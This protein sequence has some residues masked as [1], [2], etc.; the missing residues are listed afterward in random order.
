MHNAIIILDSPDFNGA[1]WD[2][3][4]GIDK[5]SLMILMSNKE[6]MVI[7]ILCHTGIFVDG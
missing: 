6:R 5:A 2:C 4:T 3:L 1:M 7:R